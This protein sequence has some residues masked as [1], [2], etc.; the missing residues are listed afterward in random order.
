MGN[1]TTNNSNSNNNNNNNN[2][3]MPLK[4]LS[5]IPCKTI[6]QQLQ[7]WQLVWVMPDFII[8]AA[9]LPL[10]CTRKIFVR[11]L[12]RIIKC[13]KIVQ[14]EVHPMVNFSRVET[15]VTVATNN[16]I[17]QHSN[18]NNNNNN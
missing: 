6:L 13:G 5:S 11:I 12:C 17:M 10:G 4:P 9:W 18:N 14:V 16:K 7:Q 2:S 15:T 1:T 3:N 8:W